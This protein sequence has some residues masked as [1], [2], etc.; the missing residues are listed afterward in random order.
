MKGKDVEV[1]AERAVR[2]ISNAKAQLEKE[3]N[4]INTL[5]GN[6]DVSD[7]SGPK[8][9]VLPQIFQSMEPKD[10]VLSGLQSIGAIITPKTADLYLSELN[11]KQELIRF[12]NNLSIPIADGPL[13]KNVLYTPGSPAFERLVTKLTSVGLH[14][15]QD[16]DENSPKKLKEVAMNWINGLGVEYASLEVK[17]VRRSFSG[18]VLVRVRVT[19]A[20]DSYERLIEIPCAHTE[21]LGNSNKLAVDPID[22]SLFNDPDQFGLSSNILIEK[23]VLDSGVSEFC[24]FY[25]ERLVQELKNAGTDIAKR[26]KLEDDFTPRL[27]FTLVGLEGFVR[28]QFAVKVSYKFNESLEYTSD[29]DILPSLKELISQ[30]KLAKC[31]ETNKLVPEECLEKCAISRSVVLRHLLVKSDI[32]D[33]RALP[34]FIVKCEYTGKHALSDEVTKSDISGHMVLISI[35]KQSAVSGK[36]AE[37]DLFDR[38]DFT[39]T[40]VLK[41]ELG[42]S[43]IS[44]K[45]YRL[46]EKIT[47]S[48]SGKVGHR[49]EFIFCSETKL[50]I[51]LNESEKCEATGKI[52]TK[53][54]LEECRVT[55]KR[56]LP[57]ELEKSTISGKK[58][59]KK[60]FVSS[61]ISG[62]KFLEDEGIKSITGKF[63][64]PIEA[65]KCIWSGQITHPDDIRTCQITDLPVHFQYIKTKNNQTYLES[66]C[67][68]LDGV[69][70]KSDEKDSWSSIVT[71]TAEI[72]GNRK[73]EIESAELSL[74]GELLAICMQVRT[75]LGLKMRHAG[76]V[77]SKKDNIVLGRIGRGKREVNGWTQT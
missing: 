37:P 21:H 45:K 4:N 41:T 68:L 3:E 71:K 60:F 74:D 44:A 7:D 17:N 35:L 16:A 51:L 10:F 63:C 58:A 19:V 24:R 14:R 12:D 64:L 42:I 31:N 57:S 8:S 22:N 54:L 5:L 26:K 61:S 20:H 62:A 59:L 36:R 66:L 50:P 48:V 27:E 39:N 76:F 52:V 1:A 11:K 40:E 73:N 32:S 46:D 49:S 70:H 30:P 47:S 56:I 43:E 34:N 15:A 6:M 23:A 75:M 13:F 9:P 2:S 53:G 25:K 28:R 55:N 69:S 72:L 65:K 33:R 77:Y 18:A 38:C 67:N 29:L